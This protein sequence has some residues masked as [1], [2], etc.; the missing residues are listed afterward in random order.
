LREDL[1]DYLGISEGLLSKIERGKLGSSAE[2][3]ARL[4]ERVREKL[5]LDPNGN[6][7]STKVRSTAQAVQTHKKSLQLL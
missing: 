6:E 2:D 3:V 5:G 4:L 7:W 1:T